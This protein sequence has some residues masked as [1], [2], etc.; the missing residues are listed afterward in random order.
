MVDLYLPAQIAPWQPR[1]R[2]QC[3]GVRFRGEPFLGK[4]PP[5]ERSV[6]WQK[7]RA[8]SR[9]IARRLQLDRACH[10]C[11][12]Q[13]TQIHHLSEDATAFVFLC[14][15]HHRAVHRPVISRQIRLLKGTSSVVPPDA[16]RAYKVAQT[17]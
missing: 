9:R 7:L 14:T 5:L 11:G 12:K 4:Y 2:T 3:D 8:K 13:G 1:R 10:L 6:E 15:K 17:R 16:R